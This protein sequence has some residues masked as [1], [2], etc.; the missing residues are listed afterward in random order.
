MAPLPSSAP[1]SPVLLAGRRLTAG[2]VAGAEA[3]LAPLFQQGIPDD[4]LALNVAGL[5]RLARG[6]IAEA[7]GLFARARPLAPQEPMLP[8]HHGRALAALN[9]PDDATAAFR[10]AL[11]LKPDFAD[12]WYGLGQSLHQCGRLEDAEDALRRLL[13]IAPVHAPA[14]LALG[15]VLIDAGKPQEAE[16]ALRPGA[17]ETADPRL[18]ARL[19]GQLGLALRRQR[20]DREALFEYDRALALDPSLEG[21]GVHRAESLQNLGRYEEALA[22]FRT[23]LAHQPGDPELHHRCNDLLYRLG[24]P[25][26]LASYDRAPP[27]RA[28]KLG[29]ASFLI[30]EKRGAEAYEIYRGLLAQDADDLTA[31]AGAA[32]ALTLM[33]RHAEASAA[34][35][36][37]LARRGDPVLFARAAEPALLAGDAPRAAAL[38]EKGLAL[39]PRDHGC[40]AAIGLAWRMME[41]ARDE[42]L[43]G[44]DTLVQAFDLEPPEGFARMEDFNAELDAWLDRMHPPT[45]EFVNQSLRGGTQTPDHLFG[46][47]HAL[48]EKLQAR[49]REAVARY[50]GAMREDRTH[51]FL[52]R[53]ARDFRYAGSWSSR[54]RDCGYHVNHI[55]PDGWISSCYYIAVPPAVADESG[56]Q[57]WIKFG[58]P[59]FDLALKNP[60]RRAIQPA[61]GRLVLFPSYMWHGTVPFH[62]AQARTTIAFDAV[63]VRS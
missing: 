56:R 54:L 55:H 2:D 47:G 60:V 32:H 42:M 1:S 12:A 24:H 25:D 26:Y 17:A 7:A 31:A 40:L 23:A 63:P 28:L 20:K 58:E 51:P 44:Y 30:H 45:R 16:A 62:D 37:L 8:F 41:D 18:K 57:G 13:R 35:D 21:L 38:C 53:R 49:I 6:Q 14:R 29:K 39:S 46:A 48:V 22:V 10:A 33:K 36:A 11:A 5:V 27:S 34:F 50:I 9:R 43:N 19:H 52:S 59:S 15:A 4:P 3:A 61:A